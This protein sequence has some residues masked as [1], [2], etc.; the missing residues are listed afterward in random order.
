MIEG[1]S[2]VGAW[3]RDRKVEQRARVIEEHRYLCVRAARRFVRRGVDRSDLE[4]IAAIGLIKAV[5]RYDGRAENPFEAYAWALILGEL[6]HHVRDGERIVR[7]P[8]RLRELERRWI[9]AERELWVLLGREPTER[10][11]ARYVNVSDRERSELQAYRA[12][13]KARSLDSPS[14][15]KYRNDTDEIAVAVDRLTIEAA[16]A[17]LSALERRILRALY[18]DQ[19]SIGELAQRVGYSRRHLTRI[20]RGALD[21]LSA[22]AR[23]ETP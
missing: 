1:P 7:A 14:V 21:R 17:R 5:D 23:P 13:A 2:C 15:L 10:D 3:V 4:Q 22:I 8:R 20:H 12:G 18:V 6:M 9:S 19:V 11:V 16:L